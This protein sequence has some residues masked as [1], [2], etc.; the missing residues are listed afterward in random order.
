MKS[1]AIV[2]QNIIQWYSIRPLAQLISQKK[3]ISLDII[4]FDPASNSE[5]Y[6]SIANDMCQAIEKDGFTWTKQPSHQYTLAL[7]PYSYM[8]TFEAKYRLGYCY[9]SA[10]TK[11]AF[12]LQPECKKDFHA[13]LLHDTY[14]AELFSV[15][16]HTYIVP[17]L[18]LKT[19]KH[20]NPSSSKTTVLYLPTYHDPSIPQVVKALS[21][22]KDNYY[23]ITK[24]HH[25]TD[26]LQEEKNKKDLLAQVADEQYA[27]DQ[28]IQ[29]LL[30]RADVVLSGNSGA[31]MDALYAKVPVAIA[32]DSISPDFH[33][34]PALQKQLTESGIIPY[35]TQISTDAIDNILTQAISKRQRSIQQKASDSLFP[36]KA[37]GAKSWY[38]II[39]K[40]LND[41]IDQNYCKLHDY[42]TEVYPQEV[43]NSSNISIQLANTEQELLT[44]KHHLAEAHKQNDL[45]RQKLS[46]Y[47]NSRAH[48]TIDKILEK[49]HNKQA[50]KKEKTT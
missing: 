43:L 22:L 15:Y 28:D 33:G 40:Y 47:T 35:T 38:D 17:E 5:D 2:T 18:R 13:I 42:Y 6:H 4:I 23:I 48:Q 46:F 50:S 31:T 39:Q 10:T 49:R 32:T 26:N 34:V 29:P 20:K 8:F 3:D 14:G 12:S 24:S 7:A 11:P 16:A 36:N 27:S 30:D 9:G 19:A 1:I 25:G 41:E 45:L 44:I 37:G 21:E